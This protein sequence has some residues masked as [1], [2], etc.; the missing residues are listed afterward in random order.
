MEIVLDRVAV[1]LPVWF[2][3]QRAGVPPEQWTRDPVVTAFVRALV[4][5]GA[6]R[7]CDSAAPTA[8]HA[9]TVLKSR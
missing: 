2:E 7:L 9:A 1:I 6:R 8:T 4:L 3:Q 5:H